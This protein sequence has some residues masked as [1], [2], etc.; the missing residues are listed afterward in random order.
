MPVTS[1]VRLPSGL[2]RPILAV[3][4]ANAIHCFAIALYG[5]H[6]SDAD[7]DTYERALLARIAGDA[8]AVYAELEINQL[9]SRIATFERQ[10]S[11]NG[12]RR[13]PA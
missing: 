4:A 12:L 2:K 9:R 13:E 5:P 6:A 1:D 7:L 8:A 11:T 3:P 10:V